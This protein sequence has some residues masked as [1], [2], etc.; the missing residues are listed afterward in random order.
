M[1]VAIF[2]RVSTEEQVSKGISIRDQR[3][4]GIEF[5]LDN[6]YEYEVF[7]EPG[8]SGN[9]ALEDRPV[10]FKLLER[11]QK[12]K[13]GKTINEPEFQAVYITDFDRVSRNDLVF[14][15]IKQHFIENDI[16]IFD[17]GVS[18]D[19]RDATTN[20][21]VSIKGSLASFEIK[22]LKERIKRALERSVINGKAGG[23][24][25]LNFG[26]TKNEDKLLVIHKE[27]AEV[28][29]QIYSMAAQGMGTNRIAQI[30][31]ERKIPTKRNS[32]KKG[33]MTIK[34]K[35]L[36]EFLWRDSVIYRI[37]TNSIYC[38]ERIYKNNIYK[39]P[40]I[41]SRKEFDFVQKALKE[42]INFKD[43]TNKYH[44][45][46]KGLIICPN[47]DNF[48]YGK[49]R[50]NLK[51]NQYM[52]CSQR[53]GNYCGNRGINI[54][55][56]ENLVWYYVLTLPDNIE[57]LV[58]KENKEYVLNLKET[59]LDLKKKLI[60]L[61]QNKNIILDEIIRNEK[62]QDILRTNLDEI[63]EKI[64]KEKES[65]SQKERELEM[66]HNHGNLISVIRSQLEPL[67][68]QVVNI[69]DKQKIIRSFVRFIVVKWSEEHGR[70]IVWVQFR[71][72]EL[73]DLSIQG[74]AEI[75]Y[76][77]LGFS[78]KEKKINYNFRIINP[79]TQIQVNEDGDSKMILD[80]NEPAFG[81]DV[82]D[83]FFDSGRFDFLISKRRKSRD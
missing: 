31:N 46:L 21:M 47:C 22:K 11:T 2:C 56:I 80:E 75:N 30:L 81:F 68:N 78:Y 36:R 70:H 9:L 41:I 66:A 49:K 82:K 39:A 53:Y 59:I 71:I 24:P 7:E 62:L 10:M 48:F 58:V 19:L 18:V 65:L 35:V 23:G 26:F 17:K 79:K 38:G 55:K 76:D 44:Y 20:L 32:S 37:L 67:R 74:I 25:L 14:P 28:V 34:G 83:D 27:E 73:S 51:D 3:E 40:A 50:E 13:K 77:K 52:C 64:I 63:A 57:K 29:R 69:K 5:C 33:K 15:V 61:E 60:D 6:K 72:S 42:R 16:I 43:T 4:R 54:D 8:Y 12:Q 1:K 45:L